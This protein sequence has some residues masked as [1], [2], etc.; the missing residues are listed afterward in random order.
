MGPSDVKE[1]GFHYYAQKTGREVFCPI[2]PELQ[3]EMETW[4]TP[5]GPYLY[6]VGGRANLRPY[7]R[8]LFSRHFKD[9]RDKIPELAGVT[10]HGLRCTAVVRLR[11][12]GLTS[13]QIQDIV[14]LSLAMIERYSRFADKIANG[15]AGLESYKRALLEQQSKTL[16]NSKTD[17]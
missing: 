12:L 9:Q 1:G 2:L 3:K 6:Q 15:K 17:T 8:R 13:S 11:R 4:Q 14:G 5:A 7:T 16:Q 10:L